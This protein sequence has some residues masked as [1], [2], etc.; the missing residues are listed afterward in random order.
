MAISYIVDTILFTL[1]GGRM[2]FQP[3]KKTKAKIKKIASDLVDKHRNRV[4][5]RKPT[6]FRFVIADGIELLDSLQWDK[7][8]KDQSFFFQRHYLQMLEGAGPENLV[9]RYVI[10]YDGIIPVAALVLQIANISGTLIGK[11]KGKDKETVKAKNPLTMLKKA[12]A[13][14]KE[15]IQEALRE[16]VLVCG[17]LLSYGFHGVAFA[18][19]IERA[20]IWPA[21][22]EALYRVRR[23]EKLSG[24][25]DFI[26]IKDITLDQLEPSGVMEKLSY[27]LLET[28]P[29]MMLEIQPKWKTYDNY[30]ASLQSKYRSSVKQQIIKPI[31]DA[32]CIIEHLTDIAGNAE[33]IHELYLEVHEGAGLRLFTLPKEYFAAFA[34]TAKKD[35]VCSII[36]REEKILGFIISLKDGETG[37][38]YHIG[39]DKKEAENL[40]LYLRLLHAAVS[41]ACE[42]GCRQFSLGRT[43]LE[44]KARLG[45]KP[46]PISVWVRHRQPVMNVFISNLLRV[47]HH[48]EAPERNPFKNEQKTE[49]TATKEE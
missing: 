1:K 2:K 49:S 4:L 38:G 10:I 5:L 22:A 42:L 34:E 37:Y 14:V 3:I 31:E 35:F 13:P 43:A 32:G 27:H 16:R 20:D 11:G 28:E 39:Y 26:L 47:A 15:K 6:G 21:I 8:V 25:T 23:A 9:P 40:P 44:P 41:D 18:P 19:N 48:D 36:K 17:N 45:A 7:I 24:K 12:L 30:L 46:E 29:N 33:R